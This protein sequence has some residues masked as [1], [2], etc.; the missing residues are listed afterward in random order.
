[1]MRDFWADSLKNIPDD[2]LFSDGCMYALHTG[3]EMSIPARARRKIGIIYAW[4]ETNKGRGYGS[5]SE[6]Q[7]QD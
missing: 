1:M 2:M 6:V 5:N 3:I 7:A 4:G